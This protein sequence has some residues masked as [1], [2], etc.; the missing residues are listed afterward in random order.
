M[1]Y[2]KPSMKMLLDGFF[3]KKNRKRE[4]FYSLFE[5]DR[6]GIHYDVLQAIIK[7]YASSCGNG[8]ITREF[9]NTYGINIL[10]FNQR[11]EIKTEEYSSKGK[12]VQSSTIS[13]YYDS[14]NF[15][16]FA[17]KLLKNGKQDIY[18]VQ[19]F[20]PTTQYMKLNSFISSI[21]S[22]IIEMLVDMMYKLYLKE[23]NK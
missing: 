7:K 11:A 15:P 17:I 2:E 5:F 12:L 13:F 22:C 4:D 19:D 14:D 9:N 10:I 21:S 23:N 3:M 8:F 1:F 6:V 16:S 18:R 20:Y